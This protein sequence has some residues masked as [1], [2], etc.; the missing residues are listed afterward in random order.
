MSETLFVLFY[1]YVADILE[2][3]V[4]HREAHLDLVRRAHEHGVLVMA[5]ATGDPV[6]SAL[7]VFRGPTDRPVREFVEADP[8][9]DAGLVSAHRIVPWTVVVP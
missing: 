5:G 8:Y 9:G 6:D 1:D 2:R 7:F 4:P 3:R